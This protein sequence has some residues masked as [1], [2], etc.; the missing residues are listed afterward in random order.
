MQS[1]AASM[2]SRLS[3]RA[4]AVRARKPRPLCCRG[5][6]GTFILLR[7]GIVAVYFGKLRSFPGSVATGGL[8]FC[9][10]GRLQAVGPPPLQQCVPATVEP[11]GARSWAASVGHPSILR[12][13]EHPK[14]PE[15]AHVHAHPA[16]PGNQRQRGRPVGFR[17]P[18][19]RHGSHCA[20]ACSKGKI[21]LFISADN[22]CHLHAQEVYAVLGSLT[23]DAEVTEH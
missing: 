12:Q 6:A 11:L 13:E 22:T 15:Y 19:V 10:A 3:A 1:A 2:G 14:E 20:P 4:A 16:R 5:V 21:C 18:D 8:R 23:E 17:T 9:L 7:R